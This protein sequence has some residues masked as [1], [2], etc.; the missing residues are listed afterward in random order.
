MWLSQLLTPQL[1]MPKIKNYLQ[2]FNY[3]N[4]DFSADV[5]KNNGLTNAWLNSSLKICKRMATKVQ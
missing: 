5:G 2:K 3:G 4:Q 1:E